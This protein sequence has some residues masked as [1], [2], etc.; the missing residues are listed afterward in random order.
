MLF[1]VEW[2]EFNLLLLASLASAKAFKILIP[3]LPRLQ[4]D[5]SSAAGVSILFSPSV[6][7]QMKTLTTPGLGLPP[8]KHPHWLPLEISATKNCSVGVTH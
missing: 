8:A 5:L 3:S 2:A 6:I 1:K 4:A 7:S